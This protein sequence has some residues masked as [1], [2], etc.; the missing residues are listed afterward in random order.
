MVRFNGN[1]FVVATQS[2]SATNTSRR[3]RRS[4]RAWMVKTTATRMSAIR[5]ATT[6]VTGSAFAAYAGDSERRLEHGH[7]R[8]H[9]SSDQHRGERHCQLRRQRRQRWC[10]RRRWRR[11]QSPW[12][13]GPAP[14]ARPGHF[15][16]FS[17]SRSARVARN[18]RSSRPRWFTAGLSVP[19]IGA[20]APARSCGPARCRGRSGRSLVQPRRSRC[21]LERKS[22]MLKDKELDTAARQASRS[23]SPIRRWTRSSA[24]T[25]SRATIPRVPSR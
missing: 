19:R 23:S 6:L 10:R 17:L 13:A 22:P 9:P 12:M 25:S 8:Q 1:S 18:P 11:L 15:P 5:A 21:G 7:Q 2:L 4:R 20:A 24:A 3:S 16:E 14:L